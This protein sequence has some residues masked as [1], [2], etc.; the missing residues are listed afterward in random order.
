MAESKKPVQDSKTNPKETDRKESSWLSDNILW[1]GVFLLIGLLLLLSNL[2]IVNVQWGEIWK[3]WPVLI[4]LVGLSVLSLRG[5]VAG[6]VYGAAAI[7]VVALVWATLTGV[8]SSPSHTSTSE[9]FSISRSGGAEKLKVGLKAGGSSLNITSADG[10]A[11]VEG[12]S[13]T[14]GIELETKSTVEGDTMTVMLAQKRDEFWMLPG[15]FGEMDVR[16]NKDLPT[17]LE[18]DAGA[19]KINA[20]FSAV[21]LRSLLIDSGASSIDLKLGDRLD[22]S[23]VTIDTGA[24]SVSIRVPESSGVRI[25]FD[26]G[27]SSKDL[28]SG[29]EKLDDKTYQSA[30]Y[31]SADKKI[32]ITVDMGVSSFKLS[33]Y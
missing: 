29:Y 24:S 11:A 23:D 2:E 14:N 1:G 3:L 18:I 32:T 12:T 31:N 21:K 28:P 22:S 4:I 20:D 19:S 7:A 15:P 27:L 33:A 13:R 10:S 5:W 16:L 17:D 25:A 6:V 9:A 30:N 26:A 8:V